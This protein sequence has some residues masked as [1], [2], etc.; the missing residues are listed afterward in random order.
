MYNIEGIVQFVVIL[1]RVS[2]FWVSFGGKLLNLLI[3]E[4][5]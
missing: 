5:S 2:H 3:I 4:L 1:K